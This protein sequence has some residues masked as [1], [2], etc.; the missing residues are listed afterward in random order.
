MSERDDKQLDLIRACSGDPVSAN[1]LA[2]RLHRVP[3]L[4][5]QMA[6]GLVVS[7]DLQKVPHGTRS[8]AWL[9]ETTD[10]GLERLAA[11]SPRLEPN[12]YALFV[13]DPL[14]PAA[15]RVL[16]EF[17]RAN[18]PTSMV[19]THGRYRLVITYRDSSLTDALE[20]QL[21]Q[22]ANATSVAIVVRIDEQRFPSRL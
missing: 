2:L 15:L 22:A 7:G 1:L 18:P 20:E 3:Q 12:D 17:V 13:Q 10:Q 6:E 9:Y 14:P 21:A 11:Q 4:A 5:R 19:R 8:N 16:A